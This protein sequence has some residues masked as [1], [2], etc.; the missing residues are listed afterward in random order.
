M[1]LAIGYYVRWELFSWDD[2]PPCREQG[3]V[4]SPVEEFPAVGLSAVQKRCGS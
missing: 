1:A 2:F 3:V 4:G